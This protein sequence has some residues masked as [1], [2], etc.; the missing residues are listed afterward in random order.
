VVI[1]S[2]DFLSEEQKTKLREA[3]AVGLDPAVKYFEMKCGSFVWKDSIG[4]FWICRISSQER[5]GR[6]CRVDGQSDISTEEDVSRTETVAG[7]IDVAIISKGD[8]LIWIK[9]KHYFDLP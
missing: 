6:N 3:F 5:T 1:D 9:R 2:V 4:L 8:G 7:P